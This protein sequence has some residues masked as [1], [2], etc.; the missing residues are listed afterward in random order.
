[1]RPLP[2]Q[3]R[4]QLFDAVLT[5]KADDAQIQ[6][7]EQL[8]QSDDV[9]CQQFALVSQ[10][11]VNLRYVFRTGA[12]HQQRRPRSAAP[13]Y[14]QSEPTPKARSRRAWLW[15]TALAATI[16]FVAATIDNQPFRAPSG[17][18]LATANSLFSK[19]PA[20]VATLTSLDQAQWQGTDLPVGYMI[21][22]GDTIELVSG[23]AQISVGFGAEIAAKGPCSLQFVQVDRVKLEYGNVAVHVAEWAKGFTVVTDAMDVVDLGTTFTVSA[24][25]DAGV[26]T[27]VIKGLV[28]VHPKVSDSAGRRG[29]LVVEGGAYGV[30]N[31]G[32]G[33]ALTM[34]V[35]SSF[36]A[37]SL[38][39]LV[40]YRPLDLS[41]T[42]VGLSE[43][44]ED[45]H[46]QVVDTP[47]ESFKRSQFVVVC[48]PDERYLENDASNS[49]WVSLPNW[50]TSQPNSCYTF[51]TSFELNGY[52][53][54]TIQFFGRLLAD[55]GIQAVRVNGQPVKVESWIDNVSKQEF[56][57][58]Q[59][60]IVNITEGLVVG[61]NVVEIDV[62]NGI[63]QEPAEWRGMPNPMALRVE[64]YAF[65]RQLD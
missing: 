52:D 30:D 29:V 9:A 65:G 33:D 53:L 62:W 11:D 51:Q 17:T 21:H 39:T 15:F 43:G 2:D 6:E 56:S 31:Q 47:E 48:K 28:R 25:K 12:C 57:H 19:P 32:R 1:M 16:L 54:S 45:P 4:M 59:F 10:L 60:R 46:W 58:S 55:N 18:T 37:A 23:E 61:K 44:D 8:L 36:D 5:G 40:P 13:V 64:W 3:A 42:G 27:S 14:S 24:D 7:L 35:P 41:N 26:Q 22:E 34:N 20:P 49:Q 50:R 38:E 63:F